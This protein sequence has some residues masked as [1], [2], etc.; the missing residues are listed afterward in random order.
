[1]GTSSSQLNGESSSSY[2]NDIGKDVRNE[3]IS[4]VCIYLCIH[5]FMFMYRYVYIYT[6]IYVYIN[7]YLYIYKYR[8]VCIVVPMEGMLKGVVVPAL[9]SQ[10]IRNTGVIRIVVQSFTPYV[11]GFKAYT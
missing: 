5:I 4:E 11:L 3:S 10:K 1:L 2:N 7:I 6:Y 8:Y 9:Q